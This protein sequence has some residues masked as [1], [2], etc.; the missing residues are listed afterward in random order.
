MKSLLRQLLNINK[1]LKRGDIKLPEETRHRLPRSLW[2]ISFPPPIH[3]VETCNETCKSIL[4][5]FDSKWSLIVPV[6]I[7]LF[8]I[9]ALYIYL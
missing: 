2:R 4:H 1:L 5:D 7:L 3:D 9:Y 8:I 6:L